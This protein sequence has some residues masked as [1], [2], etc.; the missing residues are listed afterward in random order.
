MKRKPFL[1]RKIVKT[2]KD[3]VCGVCGNIIPKGSL[4]LNENSF[5]KNEGY[6]NSYFHLEKET[7]CALEYID[8]VKPSEAEEISKIL[9]AIPNLTKDDLAPHLKPYFMTR[10][11]S[12]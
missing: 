6:T 5:H 2:R 11:D 7:G 4:A 10:G 8:V 9:Q 12:E 3:H 1:I